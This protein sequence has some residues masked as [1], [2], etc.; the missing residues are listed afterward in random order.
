MKVKL[1][2]AIVISTTILYG[3]EQTDTIK[4]K[5]NYGL[6]LSG[7][8]SLIFNEK[9]SYKK[10]SVVYLPIFYSIGLFINKNRHYF[11]VGMANE[12]VNDNPDD[13]YYTLGYSYR[14]TRQNKIV[15]VLAT[16]KTLSSF[17]QIHN[18]TKDV[19]QLSYNHMIVCFGPTFSKEIKR[20][21]FQLNLFCLT[22]LPIYIKQYKN[23]HI[24]TVNNDKVEFLKT[25]YLTEF[26]IA[27]R[28]NKSPA[29][30]TR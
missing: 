27:Y 24:P 5:L 1:F 9:K 14:I 23:G 4:R 21:K 10:T 3:Q 11:D 15:D 25:T 16:I 2:I 8:C 18:P 13:F 19:K 28:L 22:E 7:G 26:K 6:T 12:I 30:N 20:M 17:Y 29:A